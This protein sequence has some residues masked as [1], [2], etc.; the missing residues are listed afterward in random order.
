MTDKAAI[1]D[2]GA[3]MDSIVTEDARILIVDDLHSSRMLIGSVLSAAGYNDL[4]YAADGIEAMAAI[5][6]LSPDLVVLDLIMP[7]K[8]GYAVCREVREDHRLNVPIIVQSGLQEAD[9][10]LR[11]F[12]DGA[13]DIITKPIN[14]KELLSR[15]KLHL[16]RRRLID[17]LETYHRRMQDE[18]GM[19]ESM[20]LEL[21][22]TSESVDRIVRERACRLQSYY[23]ASNSLGG[24]LWQIFPVDED[25]FSLFMLDLSG[26]GVSA[27]INA[28]RVHMIA[29]E[30]VECRDDPSA[31]LEALNR[32]LCDILHVGHFATAFYGVFDR[33]ASRMDY[34]ASAAPQ[35][36]LVR[37]D[38]QVDVLESA[39]LL[40]GCSSVATYE[41]RSVTLDPGDSLFLYSDALVEDFNDPLACLE[42]GDVADLVRELLEKGGSEHFMDRILST[43]FGARTDDLSDDLTLLLLQ[44]ESS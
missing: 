20:Q 24:D 21:L 7:N 9:Q 16:E 3:L 19:A 43:R 11:V 6:E 33:T 42:P 30:Q 41:R 12:D 32:R 25:R 14:A 23:K 8:D 40:L 18:L 5:G 29:S 13:T 1:S 36:V 39:G 15:V 2:S 35:P 28:F 37:G 38:G 27:A 26:H 10:R 4:H 17:S 34:A 22:P 31:W 44:R